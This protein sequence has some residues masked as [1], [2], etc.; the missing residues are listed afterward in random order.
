MI[1]QGRSC[2]RQGCPPSSFET[3]IEDK[4]MRESGDEIDQRRE[5][6]DWEEVSRHDEVLFFVVQR[7]VHYSR[8][9]LRSRFGKRTTHLERLCLISLPPDEKQDPRTHCKNLLLFCAAS[10]RWSLSDHIHHIQNKSSLQQTAQQT[11]QQTAAEGLLLCRLTSLLRTIGFSVFPYDSLSAIAIVQQ[12]ASFFRQINQTKSSHS[13]SICRMAMILAQTELNPIYVSFL[14]PRGGPWRKGVVLDE[15]LPQK[16]DRWVDWCCM[17]NRDGEDGTR[18][19]NQS[20]VGKLLKS[21]VYMRYFRSRWESARLLLK[22]ALKQ[23]YESPCEDRSTSKWYES[24]S[25]S[26]CLQMERVNSLRWYAFLHLGLCEYLRG[27]VSGAVSA[28]QS[29]L[30][31]AEEDDPSAHLIS[32]YNLS[33]VYALCKEDEASFVAKKTFVDLMDS[34]LWNSDCFCDLPSRIV[35][36]RNTEEEQKR[37]ITEATTS[38]PGVGRAQ[39]DEIY[40]VSCCGRCQVNKLGIDCLIHFQVGVLESK[41]GKIGNSVI[42]YDRFLD[43][44]Q[45]FE[46]GHQLSFFDSTTPILPI[47]QVDQRQFVRCLSASLLLS[48]DWKRCV[49][50]VE[51]ALGFYDDYLLLIDMANALCKSHQD[52]GTALSKLDKALV[53]LLESEDDSSHFEV[54]STSISSLSEKRRKL[55]LICCLGSPKRG[56]IA[57]QIMNNR[58]VLLV[59]LGKMKEGIDELHETLLWSRDHRVVL[60]FNLCHLYCRYGRMYEASHLWLRERGFDLQR[61]YEYYYRAFEITSDNVHF[62]LE[63]KMGEKKGSMTMLVGGGEDGEELRSLVHQR[64]GE[65]EGGDCR[66]YYYPRNFRMEG[67]QSGLV[68]DSI[69]LVSLLLFDSSMLQIWS[70][71][72]R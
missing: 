25:R 59:L 27:N 24:L 62:L 33:S 19:S 1:Q 41:V 9:Y 45:R 12:A 34:T 30:D 54:S 16:L 57:A 31:V 66:Q 43:S 56:P 35:H 36:L 29:S 60:S 68:V 7:L 13:T 49:R 42:S 52:Y 64:G 71:Q 15:E 10:L 70:L 38:A 21:F 37:K 51:D 32:L 20:W 3:T 8:L 11:T 61:T 23:S 44:L 69:P 55:D 6:K 28:L 53:L 4:D 17:I 58:A 26:N 47:P 63:E 18:S 48:G 72:L 22:N 50:F 39:P 5:E 65:E 14:D 67:I 2:L 40:F 46:S